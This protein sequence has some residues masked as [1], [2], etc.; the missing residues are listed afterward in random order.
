MQDQN[1]FIW[2]LLDWNSK[3]LS[4]CF[5]LHQYPQMFSIKIL[6]KNRFGTKIVLIRYFRLKFQKTNIEFEISILEFVNM[7]SFVQKQKKLNLRPKILHLGIFGLQFSKN[8]YQIFNQ[9]TLL[10]ETIKFHAKSKKREQKYSIGVFGWN[11]G[12]LQSYF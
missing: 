1:C 4:C 2:V 6:F 3:K 5:L 11:V 7:Q 10:C 9:H 8:H 12:K